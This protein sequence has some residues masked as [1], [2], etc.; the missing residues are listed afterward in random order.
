MATNSAKF[1]PFTTQKQD[2]KPKGELVK[3]PD[4]SKYCPSTYFAI[5]Q[6]VDR[7]NTSQIYF[8]CSLLNLSIQ[9]KGSPKSI[10]FL[11][12]EIRSAFR[13]HPHQIIAAMGK[14]R[15]L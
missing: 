1:P 12:L 9:Y 10:T 2:I 6:Y 13:H 15:S 4:R 11:K 8:L 14:L 7:L 3:S 5:S